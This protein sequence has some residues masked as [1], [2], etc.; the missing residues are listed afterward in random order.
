MINGYLT[1]TEAARRVGA[2]G[3]VDYLDAAQPTPAAELSLAWERGAVAPLDDAIRIAA[4]D[5][6]ESPIHLKQ[7]QN[8]SASGDSDFA[9]RSPSNHLA[10][11]SRA[12]R[13]LKSLGC[14]VA[15]ISSPPPAPNRIR[16]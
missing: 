13:A 5:F 16:P 15:A 14:C 7:L 8:L 9:P 1:V 2:T 3:T 6:I 10:E 11:L 4:R 12:A